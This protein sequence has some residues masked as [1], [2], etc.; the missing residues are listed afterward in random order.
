[1]TSPGELPFVNQK[2]LA[3]DC[4]ALLR[5]A[6]G[7]R[8]DHFKDGTDAPLIRMGK[9]VQMLASL[10][11]LGPFALLA[12]CGHSV[13]RQA[14]VQGTPVLRAIY[15]DGAQHL[16]VAMPDGTSTLPQRDCTAPLLIDDATGRAR[17]ITRAEAANWVKRMQLAG[18]VHGTCP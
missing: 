1:M 2:E 17:Q 18:A 10:L 5:Q 14:P 7:V 15:R 9:T 6:D 11:A 3:L 12:G 4:S 8:R 13:Q 16:L